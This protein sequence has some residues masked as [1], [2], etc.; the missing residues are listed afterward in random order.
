MK[1][2]FTGSISLPKTITVRKGEIVQDDEFVAFVKAQKRLQEQLDNNW[3]MI[4]DLMENKKVATVKG[5][6]G[7]ITLATR[8]TLNAAHPL[9]PRFYKQALDTSKINAY[10]TMKGEYP[11]GVRETTSKYLS[12]K[13]TL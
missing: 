12:K 9:P 1:T 11:E 7:H 3:S 13:V 6:W 10:K 4:Q 2:S 5:N 8:K